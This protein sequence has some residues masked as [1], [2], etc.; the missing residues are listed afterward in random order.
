MKKRNRSRPK[1]KN[2]GSIFRSP[3]YQVVYEVHALFWIS[4]Q[5]LRMFLLWFGSSLTVAVP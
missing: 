4:I 1:L 2:D 5:G 3:V